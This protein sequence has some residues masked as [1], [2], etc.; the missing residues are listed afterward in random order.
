MRWP[1]TML[2]MR[3]AP[4]ATRHGD[5]DRA[6]IV[7]SSQQGASSKRGR[8]TRRASDARNVKNERDG[9]VIGP[10]AASGRQAQR[11]TGA[12]HRVCGA[13]RNAGTR[14]SSVFPTSGAKAS[15]AALENANTCDAA[16]QLRGQ[17]PIRP[18]GRIERPRSQLALAA[19]RERDDLGAHRRQTVEAELELASHRFALA[20]RDRPFGP[21]TRRTA[22]RR[23][24]RRL[25]IIQH[26]PPRM[27]SDLLGQCDG[28]IED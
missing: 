1:A 2:A 9:L 14:K 12:R 6:L 23:L 20:P 13:R 4:P 5:S 18:H 8:G 25:P 19:L 7:M 17:A 27:S 16:S 24:A 21:S 11:E 26:T 15:A 10:R 22:Q 3:R 28:R